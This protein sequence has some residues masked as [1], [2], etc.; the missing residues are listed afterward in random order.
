MAEKCEHKTPTFRLKMH[1]PAT[2][3]H[4]HEDKVIES[5]KDTEWEAWACMVRDSL[6]ILA[7]NQPQLMVGYWLDALNALPPELR[8]TLAIGIAQGLGLQIKTIEDGIEV[9][10]VPRYP[11]LVPEKSK[12]GL[13]TPQGGGS[14]LILPNDPRF[15]EKR[16]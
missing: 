7:H 10:L 15:A 4:P 2:S 12:S 5:K 16:S 8:R 1:T 11:P 9:G 3:W 13:V 6:A 14:K